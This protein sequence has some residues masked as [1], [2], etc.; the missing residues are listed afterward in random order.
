MSEDNHKQNAIIIS[1]HLSSTKCDV[2]VVG[3]AEEQLQL[4]LLPTATQR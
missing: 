3:A 4:R 1:I 2:R